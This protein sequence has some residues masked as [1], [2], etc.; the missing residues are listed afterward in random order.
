MI[1]G[2]ALKPEPLDATA[3]EVACSFSPAGR[4]VARGLTRHQCIAAADRRRALPG[5]QR[6][7]NLSAALSPVL[8]ALSLP[9]L[10]VGCELRANCHRLGRC[11]GGRLLRISSCAV[12]ASALAR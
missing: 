1:H 6:L 3:F 7:F 8:P 2:S 9:P 10:G 11:A 4:P 5:V 12:T